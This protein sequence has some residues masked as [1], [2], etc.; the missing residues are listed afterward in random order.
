M[1]LTTRQ[2]TF[3]RSYEGS[4]VV[5]MVNND[6][7]ACTMYGGAPDGKYVGVLSGREI[8]V[9]GGGFSVEIEGNSGEIW[10]PA[11]VDATFEE[12]DVKL[13]EA[14]V[15]VEM[16]VV[17]LVVEDVIETV[18]GDVTQEVVTEELAA[19]VVEDVQEEDHEPTIIVEV[20]PEVQKIVD[21]KLA[22]E[23][24]KEL[25]LNK[26]YE[27]MSI[28]ELQASIIAKMAKNGPVT[29]DM[30]RTVEVN[31]H[32]GSLLTWVRSFN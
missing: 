15:K 11:T 23:Q 30:R 20:A 3:S 18:V 9:S 27:E 24:V 29:D 28:E 21:E 10:V 8:T 4:T 26:P 16:P 1:N 31:T 7:N 14:P 25:D 19:P 22:E 12:I 2:Y 32:H 17:E 13:D 5:V 6:D